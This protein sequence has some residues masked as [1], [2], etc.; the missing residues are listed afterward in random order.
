M[1]P[2]ISSNPRCHSKIFGCRVGIPFSTDGGMYG[3]PLTGKELLLYY[4]IPQPLLPHRALW[5]HL[6]PII[7]ALIPGTLPLAFFHNITS[8]TSR[9]DRIYDIFLVKD[10]DI[11]HGAQCYL[12]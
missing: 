5:Y 6:D 9:L 3:R 12:Q 1:E 7:D 2:I 4:S 11:S 8:P 10:D